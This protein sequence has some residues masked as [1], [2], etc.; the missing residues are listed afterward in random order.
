MIDS[1]LPLIELHRHLD[2]SVRLETIL[3][4]GRRHNLALPAWDV[5]GLRPYVQVLDPQPGIM[6]FIARFEWMT[7]VLVDYDACRR[8]AY[9]SVED[10]HREGIDYIELRFSPLFMAEPH[11]LNPTGVV[12]AVVDGVAAA[13][14]DF[15]QPCGLLGI[16]SRTYG[17]ETAWTE[18][19]ALLSQRDAIRGLDLA[20]DE[21]HDPGE[22][23]EPH[24][25][26]AREAGWHITV[27][28]GEADGPRSI[29]QALNGL[30]AERIGHAVRAPEDPALMDVLA[31]RQIGIE[32]NLTSN[33]QTTT[34]PDY[35]SHPL[36]L[37]LE[38]GLCATLNTDDPG[39]S[40]ITLAH[41]Y[42]VAAPAAGLDERMI[43]QAQRNALAAA[44]LTPGERQELLDCCASGPD[45]R[46]PAK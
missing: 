33:V 2:G 20:G 46:P 41:E 1:S 16:L 21:A 43:R 13:R 3:D 44:F 36:R 38:R 12:E 34:V 32:A 37:F 45:A 30:G 17:P 10:A 23:F 22:W 29:W 7:G 25:A 39:I 28:A 11:E 6:A 5:E 31:E 19:R 42:D 4:L 9:E 24:F 14:R 8:V 35:A 40:G 27:H 26:C 15:D 18:L